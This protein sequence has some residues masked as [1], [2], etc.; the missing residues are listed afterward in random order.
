[1]GWGSVNVEH[2]A[3]ISPEDS[4]GCELVRVLHICGA[5]AG[6]VG[7]VLMNYYRHIDR[8]KVQ[9]DFLTHGEPDAATRA[10]VEMM[11]GTITVVTP[12]STSLWRNLRETRHNINSNSPHHVVHVHTAS[13]TSFVYLL[14]AK[15][16]GKRVRVAHSHATSLETSHQSLQ[17]RLHRTL[18]PLL[19]AVTTDRMACSLAAGRWLFGETHFA[20]EQVVPNAIEIERFRFNPAGREEVRRALGLADRLVIGHVGRFAD[21]KNHEFLIR[22]F[23]EVVQQEPHAALILAGEGPLMGDIRQQV[24]EAGLKDNVYFLGNRDDIPALLSAMDVFVLPSNF[25]GLPLVL[26]ETQAAA[27]PCLVST[28]VTREIALTPLVYFQSL[29][30][31][32]RSWADRVLDLAA[33][34]RESAA[35]EMVAAVGYDISRAALRLVDFYLQGARS[36]RHRRL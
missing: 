10:E 28:E 33:Q 14:V 5:L 30:A 35:S 11:G 3:G 34:P 17:Y 32:P 22:I 21:E 20:A 15:L 16:A 27:L 6:G 12:K 24:A 36:R 9:F 2:P 7:T 18:Q 29:S 4:I 1:M 23:G 26:V 31:A 13:P 8:T 19:R 25:E